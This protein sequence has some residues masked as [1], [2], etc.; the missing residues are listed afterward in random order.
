MGRISRP[1]LSRPR[2]P[3][4]ANLV[5][6][7]GCPHTGTIPTAASHSSS[8]F[9]AQKRRVLGYVP[10]YLR[11]PQ[12]ASPC[13]H[14]LA[15]SFVTCLSYPSIARDACFAPNGI[16]VPNLP[17]VSCFLGHPPLLPP[18]HAWSS[19][20]GRYKTHDPPILTLRPSGS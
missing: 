19:T 8:V 9:G 14:P 20:R 3:R 11:A 15:L 1:W 5:F 12:P 2:V 18:S 13:H 16:S 17:H 6:I 10:R 4:Q 7:M